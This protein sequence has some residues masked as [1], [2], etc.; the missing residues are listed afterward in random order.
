MAR[1]LG[2]CST[3]LRVSHKKEFLTSPTNESGLRLWCL[4]RAVDIKIL[5][6]DKR[7]VRLELCDFFFL[8]WHCGLRPNGVYSEMAKQIEGQPAVAPKAR[9]N[10][11]G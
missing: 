2:I 4:V 7:K 8:R 11:G 3:V 5:S 6:L 10:L 1:P 9:A